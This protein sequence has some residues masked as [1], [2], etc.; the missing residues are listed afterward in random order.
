MEK[1]CFE[2]QNKTNKQKQTKNKTKKAL[3]WQ[4]DLIGKTCG[5][6]CEGP[7]ECD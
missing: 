6:V 7:A 5:L 4:I 1:S 2:K 3:G